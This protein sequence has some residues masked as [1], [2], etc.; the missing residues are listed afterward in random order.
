MLKGILFNF[1][2]MTLYERDYAKGNPCNK[3]TFGSY[4]IVLVSLKRLS[5]YKKKKKKKSCDSVIVGMKHN[6]YLEYE[7]F[8]NIS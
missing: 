7:V 8:V 1:D 3:L 2:I 6:G 4:K 5:L